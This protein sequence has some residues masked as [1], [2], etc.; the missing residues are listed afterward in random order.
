M[1]PYFA[2]YYNAKQVK[3]MWIP[4]VFFVSGIVIKIIYDNLLDSVN[5][6]EIYNAL[7][8]YSLV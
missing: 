8:S 3:L 4:K 7:K 6:V 1:M 2:F 5:H